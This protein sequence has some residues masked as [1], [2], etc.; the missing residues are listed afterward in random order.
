MAET[1]GAHI[2]DRLHGHGVRRVYGY[3]GDGINGLLGAFH[4]VE[5]VEFIQAA[6]E[7]LAAFMAC[8]HAK[9][10]GDV[11]VCLATSGPGAIHLLNGLY[12]AKLDHQPVVAIVGQQQTLAL[13]SSYQQEV[14]LGSLF[15]DVASEYVQVALAPGQVTHLI[16]RAVQIARA[17]RSVTCVIVPNDLQEEPY[18]PPPRAHGSVFTG[19]SVPRPRVLP[20]EAD[21]ARAAAVLN[22]GSKVAMLVGAGARDAAA[23]V[24]QVAELLGAGVA[25]ALNGRDVLPDDLPYVT[26]SIGLL[27]TKPSDVM[28]QGCDTLLMVGSSFPYSEWLPEPGQARGVQIDLDATRLGIRYPMEV[29]LVG[30]AG[31][32]L[33]ALIPLLERKADRSWR[34]EIEGEIDRWWRVLA[35]RAEI[36]ASPLNPLKV[37]HELSPRLPDGCVIT[38]D[39]G[40]GTNWWARHLRFRRGMRGALSGT[41]ATMGPALPY[42]LAAK[43]VFPDRPGDRRRGRRRDADERAQRAD[44]RGQAPRPLDGPAVHRAGARTTATSTRS[45]G[46]SACWPATRSSRRRS[47]FPTSRT[48]ATR[49]CS[50]SGAS[51]STRRRRSGRRGTRRWR[52]TCRWSTRRSPTPRCRRCRRTSSSS[53]REPREGAGG[54]RSGVRLDDPAGAEGQAGRAV[55]R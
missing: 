34:E 2:L 41:L 42:A 31:E 18:E 8:A 29:N 14:D 22:A 35:D 4:E 38:A 1:V 45:R 11:G 39:S 16:D 24:E 40:S 33:R 37:F 51:A 44:R 5:D 43:F 50:G 49:S 15:K 6:H 19:G 21:L 28:M 32:T 25:K 48:R 36:E 55:N 9:F 30:D 10:S 54:A 7:E 27:G 12:D 52:P 46:S 3:P 17:T 23:E 26:G 47:A 53:R 13:G 20:A